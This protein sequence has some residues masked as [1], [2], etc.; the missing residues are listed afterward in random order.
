VFTSLIGALL[1]VVQ[2]QIFGQPPES[3]T[4]EATVGLGGITALILGANTFLTVTSK[5]AAKAAERSAT[6]AAEALDLDWRPVV[7]VRLMALP[8]PEGQRTR[9]VQNVGRGP[10]LHTVYLVEIKDP[11]SWRVTHGFSLAGG[12]V[13]A[14]NMPFL[15]DPQLLDR[16]GS[17][18]W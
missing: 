18:I 11:P 13:A 4:A 15:L 9:K 17:D 5:N 8:G 7:V 3:V 1:A 16:P 6:L 14:D 10:A 12:E 2:S